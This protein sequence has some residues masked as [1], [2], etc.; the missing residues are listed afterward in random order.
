MDNQ[1]RK[2]LALTAGR[3][4]K[5]YFPFYIYVSVVFDIAV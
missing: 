2:P 5:N 1:K 3:N 4:R